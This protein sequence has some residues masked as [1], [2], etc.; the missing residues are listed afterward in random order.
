MEPLRPQSIV[1]IT[2]AFV[3]NDC[4]QQWQAYF[5]QK[6]YTTIAPSWP[7]KDA[8]ADVL[9]NRHPDTGIAAN[10]LADLTDYYARIVEQLP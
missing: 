1:F 8:P 7:H 4:W 3:S 2:G 6:G 5:N 10:R 9:R